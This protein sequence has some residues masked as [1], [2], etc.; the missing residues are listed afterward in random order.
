MLPL[1]SW[2]SSPNKNDMFVLL[3]AEGEGTTIPQIIMNQAFNNTTSQS[4]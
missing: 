3:D 4:R 1:S 2:L